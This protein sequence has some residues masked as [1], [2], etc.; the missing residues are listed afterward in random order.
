MLGIKFDLDSASC[1]RCDCANPST[2]SCIILE[3]WV[4]ANGKGAILGGLH[5]NLN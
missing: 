5:A 2:A 1:D 3:G 4:E